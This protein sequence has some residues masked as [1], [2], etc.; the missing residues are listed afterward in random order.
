VEVRTSPALLN[1]WSCTVNVDE[2]KSIYAGLGL[3]KGFGSAQLVK[4]TAVLCTC[5]N[6]MI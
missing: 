6:N 2:E 4:G 1:M 5:S 3:E